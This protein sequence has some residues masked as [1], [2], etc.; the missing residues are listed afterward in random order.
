M[1]NILKSNIMDNQEPDIETC[2]LSGWGFIKEKPTFTIRDIEWKKSGKSF[3][4]NIGGYEIL[5][6]KSNCF[7]LFKDGKIFG[8]YH[9]KG[10]AKETAELDFCRGLINSLMFPFKKKSPCHRTYKNDMEWQNASE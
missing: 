8:K 4:S 3:F 2:M 6:I 1:C 7:L 5:K 9:K 10:L